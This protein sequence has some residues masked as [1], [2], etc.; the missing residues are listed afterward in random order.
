MEYG[1]WGVP[2]LLC[3]LSEYVLASSSRSSRRRSFALADGKLVLQPS[4]DHGY[5]NTHVH[6]H[7]HI[8]TQTSILNGYD[9]QMCKVLK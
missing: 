3:D 9:E 2:G 7:T 5:N 4:Y 1:V 8:D 6:I